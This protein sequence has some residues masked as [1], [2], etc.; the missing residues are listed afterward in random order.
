M[1]RKN[2]LLGEINLLGLNDFGSLNPLYGTAIGGG[3]AAI[4]SMIVAKTGKSADRD[5]YGLIAGLTVAGGMFFMPSTKKAAISAALG[6]FLVSGLVWLEK[7][8]TNGAG[9][10]IPSIQY[11]NGL[12][13]PQVQYLNGLGIPQIMQE[14]HA[15]GTI[16][17]VAGPSFAGSRLG[18]S[19]PVD[20]LGAMTPQS[21]K[22]AL[23]GGPAVHGLSASYGATLLGGGR[24]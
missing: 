6:A 12:G 11:L 13:I 9:L 23:M 14:P 3:V 24:S 7:K 17:G 19:N 16:P 10:G 18:D 8:L 5:L 22:I 20:L 21:E 4:T 1:A 2:S 15:Q